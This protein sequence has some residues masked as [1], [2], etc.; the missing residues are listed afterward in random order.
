MLSAMSHLA[1]DLRLWGDQTLPIAEGEAVPAFGL[2]RPNGATTRLRDLFFNH[3][4]AHHLVPTQ[5]PEIDF[6]RGQTLSTQALRNM[7]FT[8]ILRQHTAVRQLGLHFNVT[9]SFGYKVKT[10]APDGPIETVD[11]GVVS[12]Q[13]LPPEEFAAPCCHFDLEADIGPQ[14]RLFWELEALED[15]AVLQDMVL[16]LTA[17]QDTTGRMVVVM[18]TFGRSADILDLLTQFETQSHLSLGLRRALRNMFFLVLDTSPDAT[19]ET[20][21]DLARFTQL[22]AHAVAG[23]NLGGGG[24]MSQALLCLQDALAESG[25]AIDELLLLDDD[26]QVSLESLRRHWAMTLFRADEAIHTLPVCMKTAPR[27]IWEDGAFW[28]RFL[29]PDRS[30]ARRMIAPRLLRHNSQLDDPAHSAALARLHYPE[31]STFIFFGLSYARFQTLAIRWPFSCAAMTS[32]T[33]CAT[34]RMG[35]SACQ[36]PISAPGMNR[37]ILMARNI[38]P[39]PMG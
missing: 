28:G 17:P 5:R 18:R 7:C 3:D 4:L 22:H 31:Y 21:A 27:R 34:G 14:A 32:N 8:E 13:E 1:S 10:Q 25:L 29:D 37:R 12:P 6:L 30:G 15:E 35:G 9:A 20:Y 26:L 39:S 23:V 33:A 24:N 19:P 36:T 2:D 38:C 11:T 16:S